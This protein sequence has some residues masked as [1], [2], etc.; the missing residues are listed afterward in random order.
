MGSV[1]SQAKIYG[2]DFYSGGIA[3]ICAEPH[4]PFQGSYGR[5]PTSRRTSS[6]RPGDQFSIDIWSLQKA[7]LNLQKAAF[8]VKPHRT[9]RNLRLVFTT[10][11]LPPYQRRTSHYA[12]CVDTKQVSQFRRRNRRLTL[13]TG[14]RN[15]AFYGIVRPVHDMQSRFPYLIYK[16][17]LYESLQ[18][19]DRLV[20]SL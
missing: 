2:S 6:V 12:T 19:Y 4:E 8:I 11:S 18:F 16:G 9:A 5:Q 7:Q 3:G 1:A 14:S 15:V 13:S 20:T 17:A 10:Y